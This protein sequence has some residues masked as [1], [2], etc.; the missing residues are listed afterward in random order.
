MNF[1][2]FVEEVT[3]NIQLF[4]PE[5]YMDAEV[6]V[7]GNQKLNENYLGMV[8]RKEDQSIAPTINLNRLYESYQ[9]NP[10]MTM[11]AVCRQVADVIVDTPEMIDLNKIMD[12][13]IAKNNLFIRVS[14]AEANKEML[15]NVPHQLMEDLAITYHISVG[16]DREGLSSTIISNEM[17]EQYGI[18]QEQLHEDAMKSAA[19]ILPPDIATIGAKMN[20]LIGD[21]LALLTSEEREMMQNILRD[22]EQNPMFIVV[23]NKAQIN[24]AGAIFYPE[25]MENMGYLVGGDFFILPSSVHETL[26]LP[27]D[28]EMDAQ[29]LKEMVEEVNATQ[30]LPQDRLTNEVYHYDTKN[31]VF[32]KANRFEERQKEKDTQKFKVEKIE[33]VQPNDMKPKNKKHD[34]EL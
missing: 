8:V 14:S 1:N 34:L 13:D 30:V 6:S 22:D 31:H 29:S 24:G 7:T 10:G 4:L 15:K 21:S 17:M 33:K 11:E 2:N 28:G 12:Y 5:D 9:D 32:E 19:S 18:T 16:M 3:G 20:N 26:V 25:V 23:T 27:D